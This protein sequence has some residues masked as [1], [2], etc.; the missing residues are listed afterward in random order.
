MAFKPYPFAP[1]VSFESAVERDANVF[2]SW[3][4]RELALQSLVEGA[5]VID[6]VSRSHGIEVNHVAVCGG[7]SVVLLLQVAQRLGQQARANQKHERE[8]R[9]Q[10]D[11]GLLRQ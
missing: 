5:N 10:H 4:G 1:V 6:L 2:H 9:L 8:S 7:E 11:E 3:H